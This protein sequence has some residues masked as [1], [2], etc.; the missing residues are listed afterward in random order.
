M[1][2]GW[3]IA[4]TA[5]ASGAKREKNKDVQP[6]NHVQTVEVCCMLSGRVNAAVFVISSTENGPVVKF[7]LS[8]RP[9]LQGFCQT[10]KT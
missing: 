3:Y 1:V 10:R 5:N 7:R 8:S 6:V 2:F 9:S 4:T